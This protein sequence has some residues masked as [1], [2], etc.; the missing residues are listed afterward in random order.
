[1]K[2][3]TLSKFHKL[4]IYDVDLEVIVTDNIVAAHN[5]PKRKAR[6]GGRE[7]KDDK[8]L[9]AGLC[10]DHRFNIGIFLS[11]DNMDNEV[12]NHELMHGVQAVLGIHQVGMGSKHDQETPALLM[13]Y[14]S[15]LVYKDLKDWG[16]KVK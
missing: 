2:K 9:T 8:N 4:P 15:K 10:C 1:M 6:L 16:I 12:I 5:T 14:L 13:G 11:Y 3:K 7:F